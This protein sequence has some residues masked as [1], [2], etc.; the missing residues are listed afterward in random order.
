M[1]DIK[2]ASDGPYLIA[3]PLEITDPQG[4]VLKIAEGKTAALCRCGH[5]GNKPF[6]DGQHKAQSWKGSEAGKQP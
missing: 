6:C 5:S 4:N 3:G 2:C 1:T